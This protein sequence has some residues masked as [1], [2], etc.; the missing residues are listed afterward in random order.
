[1]S[2]ILDIFVLIN[3]FYLCLSLNSNSNEVLCDVSNAINK[4]IVCKYEYYSYITDD[5]NFE[6][7]DNIT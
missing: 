3:F 2:I 4:N 7:K 5:H 6:S 1:M